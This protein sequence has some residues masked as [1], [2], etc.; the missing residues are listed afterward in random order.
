MGGNE[1]EVP[2]PTYKQVCSGKTG[3][4]ETIKIIFNP[5]E[6]S[7]ETL[8]KIFFK[9]HNPTTKNRQGFDIGSQYRSIIFYSNSNQKKEAEKQIKKQEEKYNR[10][11]VTEFLSATKHNFFSAED[12]HQKYYLK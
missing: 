5:D 2:N 10:K 7:Y 4:A 6:I 11:I 1:K 9:I 12:Y 3:Y 8:L